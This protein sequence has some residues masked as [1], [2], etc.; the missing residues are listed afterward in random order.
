MLYK[1]LYKKFV[2]AYPSGCVC[3]VKTAKFVDDEELS[4]LQV[5]M[6]SLCELSSRIYTIFLYLYYVLA[7]F[8]SSVLLLHKLKEKSLVYLERKK[9]LFICLVVN[10]RCWK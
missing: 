6:S 5:L 10:G 4:K 9:V 1:T 2:P 8:F 3:F 7:V